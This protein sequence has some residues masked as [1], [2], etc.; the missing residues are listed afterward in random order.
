MVM[1]SSHGDPITKF[2]CDWKPAIGQPNDEMN[3][4]FCYSYNDLKNFWILI[5][6][7]HMH[8]KGVECMCKTEYSGRVQ[9]EYLYI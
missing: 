2:S 4:E 1:V 8:M 5:G 3:D 6:Q 9:Y 7:C